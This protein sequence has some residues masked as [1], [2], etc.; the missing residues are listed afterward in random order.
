MNLAEILTKFEV[1]DLELADALKALAP[2]ME[3]AK[4][5]VQAEA[6][7]SVLLDMP[8]EPETRTEAELDAASLWESNRNEL[9]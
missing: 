9:K 8:E 2:Y 6:I 4:T 5:K 7:L 3:N 1:G